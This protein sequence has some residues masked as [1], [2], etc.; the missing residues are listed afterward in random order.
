MNLHINHVITQDKYAIMLVV[1]VCVDY[2]VK[3]F[4]SVYLLSIF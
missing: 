2:I 3:H 1:F 4:K